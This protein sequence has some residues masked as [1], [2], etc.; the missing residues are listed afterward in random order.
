MKREAIFS[1]DRAYRYRL[2]RTWDS[3]LATMCMVMLNPSKADERRDDPTTTFC[4]N[5][6]KRDGFGRYIAVN[7]F[8]LVGTDPQCLRRHRD[9]V[10]A[11]N[12]DHILWGIGQA[13]RVI[14]AWG[15]GGRRNGL[16]HDVLRLIGH[17]QLHCFGV[18]K[19][20]T[21]RFPR[22]IPRIVEVVPYPFRAVSD[23]THP[24]SNSHHA[25]AAPLS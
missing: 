9:P 21:P 20:G 14:V 24:A 19:S 1:P 7:L 17:V 16:D 13:N 18:N 23:K 12:V 5:I 22:A 11:H 3:A 8:A 25:A 4:M 15:D 6:A 10:G 2:V